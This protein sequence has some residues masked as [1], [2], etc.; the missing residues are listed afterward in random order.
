MTSTSQGARIV[1]LCGSLRAASY[2]HMALKAAGELL[3]GARLDEILLPRGIPIYDAD[4]QAAGWPASVTSMADAIRQADG[5]LI[6]SP[7]YNFSIPGGLKNALDWL[8]RLPDQ[9][10]KGKPVAL[11]GAATGPLGTARVQYDLRRVLQ[12]LEADVLLKPEVFIGQCASRFD[13]EG[14]LTDEA[15]RKFLEAQMQ[16]FVRL[17]GRSKRLAALDAA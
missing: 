16:A 11:L 17:I 15:T 8:S 2:N 7:E 10:F 9:P 1:A 3:A 6:A 13:A 12:F 5:V 4:E 14:R